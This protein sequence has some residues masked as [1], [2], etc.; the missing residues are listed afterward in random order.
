MAQPIW[1]PFLTERDRQV[2][3]IS[4]YGGSVGFGS[5]PA[6]LIIDVTVAFCGEQ[7]EPI[8]ESIKKWRNSCG[9]EAWDGVQAIRD[10]IPA[11]RAAG[12][13]IIYS[14]GTP[15]PPVAL[16]SGRWAQKNTRRS[17]DSEE[18]KRRGYDIVDAISPQDGDIVIRKTKPSAF[19]GTPLLSYLI[20]LGTDTLICCGTSTS[21]CVRATVVDAFS[22]NFRV[23]VVQDATFDRTQSSHALNLYDM[24]QK[25]ADVISA[26]QAVRYLSA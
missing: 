13:P 2:A 22:N 25:Y 15:A 20:E 11:A 26:E 23:G 19:F 6:L 14:A 4:G 8:L 9:V 5:H 24:A 10:I 21:G 17:E 7:P 18:K 3:E 1:E 12:V 16:Y